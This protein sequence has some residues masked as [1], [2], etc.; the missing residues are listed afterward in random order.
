LKNNLTAASISYRLSGP[1]IPGVKT[2]KCSFCL[3]VFEECG[4]IC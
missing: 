2:G 4:D 1:V 3:F